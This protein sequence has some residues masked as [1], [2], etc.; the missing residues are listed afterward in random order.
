MRYIDADKILKQIE[1]PMNWTD[2]EAELQQQADYQIFENLIENAPTEDVVPRAEVERLQSILLQFTDIVHKW[3]AKNNFDTIEISLVPILEKEAD[4]IIN[5][6]KQEVARLK[7][8]NNQLEIDIVN[9]NM[10]YDHILQ[11]IDQIQK[12]KAEITYLKE[13]LIA[14]AKQE[15]VREIFKE[16]NDLVYNYYS[17]EF[18]EFEGRYLKLENK[19]IGEKDDES[20]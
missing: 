18:D 15:V 13:Q 7:E 10:N 19:Y 3:G 9:A 17:D 11:E 1:P 6:A 8:L 16:M 14:K 12:D 2:S 20:K 5:K 4:S